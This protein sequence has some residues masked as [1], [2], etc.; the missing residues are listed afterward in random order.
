MK[1]TIDT[2]LKIVIIQK[3]LDLATEIPMLLSCLNALDPIAKWK[4]V[5]DTSYYYTPSVGGYQ[6]T[7]GVTTDN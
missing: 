1:F 5:S 7:Y 3:P 2:D 6:L 4:I